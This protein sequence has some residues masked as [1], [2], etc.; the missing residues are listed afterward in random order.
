MTSSHTTSLPFPDAPADATQAHLFPAIQQHSLLSI[1]KFCDNG[2]QA[3]FTNT[4]VTIHKPGHQS[5]TGHRDPP[6]GLWTI[7]LNPPSPPSPTL[8][9][10]SAYTTTNK[11]DLAQFL[12]Q[13][14]YSPTSSALITA[15][16]HG[17]FA[18][19][20]GLTAELIR[21]HLPKSDATVKGHLRQSFKNLRST[22]T[23]NLVPT[24][25]PHTVTPPNTP[26]ESPER[27]HWVYAAIFQPTGQIHTDQTGR[28]PIT[29]SKGN[30]YI[31]ILYDYDSN[32][33]IA[34]PLRSRSEH[35][36]VTAYKSLHQYLGDRGLKP[37]LQRLDNEAPGGL[38]QFMTQ[39]GV[40][41]QLVPPHNHRRNAAERAISI[42]KDHFIAGLSTTDKNWPMHLWCRLLPQAQLTLNLLRQSRLNPRL[43]AEAQLNGNFD[44]NATPLAPPGTRVIMHDKANVRRTFAPHGTDGWYLGPAREH[45][46]CYRLYNS[47][48][49]HER[50]NDTVEFFPTHANM[51]YCSAADTAVHAAQELTAAL[52]NPTP[53]AP[54]APIGDEQLAAIQ[55]LAIIFQKHIDANQPAPRVVP[56]PPP[57]VLDSPHQ[58]TPTIAPDNPDDFT[59]SPNLILDHDD[60]DD[61]AAS[62]PRVSQSPHRYPTRL[63]QH[64]NSV[65]FAANQPILP[66]EY[67]NA[68]VDDV[69]GQVYEYRHL[70]K[71]LQREIWEHSFANEIGRLA[72]GVGTRMPT[73]TNTI[74]FIEKSAV[75]ADRVVTYGRICVNIR[76]QKEETHRTRLT[77][78]GNLIDYPDDVSTPTADLT[79]AKLLFNSVVSTRRARFCV[80][81]IKDFYLNTEMKRYE[82][83]RIAIALIPQEIIDQYNLMDLA[84]DGYVYI[85]IRK[86]MY[87]LP[88]AGIIA[89]QKLTKHLAKYGY[90]PTKHTPG[91]WKHDQ[92]PVTFSLVVDDFGIKY[93]GEHNAQH[94]LDAISDLYKSTVDWK[95]QLYCGI[96]LK[97]DYDQRTVELSMPGYVKAALHKFQHPAPT[98]PQHS[99]YPWNQPQH[100]TKASQESIAPDESPLLPATDIKRIQKI[101]GTLLYYGR[102]IDNTM[103]VSL[104]TL[105]AE[106]SKG[107]ENTAKAIVHLLNYCAT[108]PDAV[109]KYHASDMVLHIDSDASYLSLPKARSRVGGHH[110]LSDRSTNDHQAPTHSPTPN[111]VVHVVCQKLQPVVASAAESEVGGLF[112][113]GQ[114]ATVLRTTLEDMGHSQPPTPIKTDNSTASGIANDT[115]KQ[116]RSRAMEMRFYWIRDRVNQGQFL[117]YWRPGDNNKGDYHTKHH[118]A[119][120]HQLMRSHYLHTKHSRY[121]RQ[122]P[123]SLVMPRGCVNSRVT[124]LPTYHSQTTHRPSISAY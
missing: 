113:N 4:T 88:Q 44:F 30:K 124:Q 12:H 102:A 54:F 48:T 71:T 55:Q 52:K 112:V 46:R 62:A 109:I 61:D 110:Y 45:Y 34:A 26:L 91:L 59:P 74:F 80:A 41:Y 121:T 31:M 94:L 3:T 99:P 58:T 78:G 104:N 7:D 95:G 18:T 27:T 85:E 21:K 16:Q 2:Y 65:T 17:N 24:D 73:G 83:M 81:D 43:S 19:W 86:G 20:P 69:T 114:E 49:G 107:T 68:V 98:V 103:L 108:H 40:Q 118:T 64:A 87:G 84:V 120:H 37:Q 38:K 5:I 72:Q 51:P 77:V 28:F 23:P 56:T 96:S 67:V 70:I 76:P 10:N 82:Y 29:S 13:C 11:R 35:D 57:R 15:I 39:Q 79:T 6:T 97:W 106:Q 122:T 89:N 116:R 75:P 25:T 36:L 50:I 101:V 66:Q 1:G 33:I 53:A 47:K 117:V 60:D 93:V 123:F 115:I 32:A 14:C 119:A 90:R 63:S 8:Q 9:A 22:Q 100:N 92:R 42:F 105:A 111:G